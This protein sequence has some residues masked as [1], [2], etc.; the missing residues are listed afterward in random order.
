M[1]SSNK[2]AAER[3]RRYASHARVLAAVYFLALFIGTH[4]PPG[5]IGPPGFPD[6]LAHLGG[7][8]ILAV[9]VL[10]VWELSTERLQAR[11]FFAVWLA[12]TVYGAIDEWTQI[13]V[14]RTCDMNDWGADVLGVVI[15]IVAY[16]LLR[17]LL[18]AVIG[19]DEPAADDYR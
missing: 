4:L 10:A 16:Q 18:F 15:G 6:K 8:A 19:C 3:I 14:G 2:S 1:S 11:H 13:P 17:P 12:G 9:L 5:E 7:Y